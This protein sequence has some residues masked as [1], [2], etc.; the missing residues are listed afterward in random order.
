MCIRD[1]DST[2]FAVARLW[3]QDGVH[4][5]SQLSDWLRRHMAGLTAMAEQLQ[6]EGLRLAGG[7]CVGG[8]VADLRPHAYLQDYMQEASV[9][10]SPGGD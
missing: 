6:E 7:E 8:Q 4:E 9:A 3:E 5:A 1:R 10:A 2:L